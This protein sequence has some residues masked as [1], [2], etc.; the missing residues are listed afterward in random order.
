[1]YMCCRDCLFIWLT[2]GKAGK[3][4]VVVASDATSKQSVFCLNLAP[5]SWR[6]VSH[7]LPSFSVGEVRTAGA[8]GVEEALCVVANVLVN[9]TWVVYIYLREWFLW[10]CV[11]LRM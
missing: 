11:L 3:V 10:V 7:V 2:V 1:M 9:P 8:E 5:D 4:L 6:G